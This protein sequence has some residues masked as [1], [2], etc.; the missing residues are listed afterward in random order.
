MVCAV[1]PLMFEH[2]Y[3]SAQNK[4]CERVKRMNIR[5]VFPSR[6]NIYSFFFLIEI[7]E[8]KMINE[9]FTSIINSINLY[10]YRYTQ[11]QKHRHQCKTTNYNFIHQAASKALQY[12]VGRLS[13]LEIQQMPIYIP[14]IG[15][16]GLNV[17]KWY[18]NYI[19]LHITL[20]IE[21]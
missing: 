1:L 18:F 6:N 17:Y 2:M 15:E 16:K 11:T 4:K 9:I 8:L 14:W 13:L 5:E 21:V 7:T 19:Y 10:R 3:I 20:A 12:G